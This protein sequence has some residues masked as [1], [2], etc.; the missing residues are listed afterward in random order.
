MTNYGSIPT[1]FSVTG[2]PSIP[3][4]NL[5]YNSR[6]KDRFQDDIGTLRPWK[7]MLNL[8]SVR[9]PGTL[10]DALSRLR[11]NSPYF[12]MN[13]ALIALGILFLGLFWHPI[14]L[15]VFIAA[16]AWWMFVYFLSDE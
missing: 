3:Y 4:S 7:L 11:T 10:D 12:R 2:V 1:T 9:I 6:A 5:A 16:M 8:C 14:S 13:Y 15:I